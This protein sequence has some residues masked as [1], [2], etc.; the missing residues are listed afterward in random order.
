MDSTEPTPTAITNH[1]IKSKE[2]A[3]DITVTITNR[4]GNVLASVHINTEAGAYAPPALHISE[5]PEPHALVMWLDKRP[6]LKFI[7]VFPC[8]IVVSWVLLLLLIQI[9]TLYLKLF[10]FPSPRGGL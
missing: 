3:E 4:S 9:T 7:V 8:G 5:E 1:I 2:N 6:I 10:V